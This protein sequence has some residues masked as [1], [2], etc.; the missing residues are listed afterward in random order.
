MSFTYFRPY[1]TVVDN[2]GCPISIYSRFLIALF[3]LGIGLTASVIIKE[4]PQ[5]EVASAPLNLDEASGP[6]NGSLESFPRDFLL[7]SP[8]PVGSYRVPI[9][10]SA[11]SSEPLRHRVGKQ[12]AEQPPRLMD[13]TYPGSPALSDSEERP[14]LPSNFHGISE[15]ELLQFGYIRHKTVNGDRLDKLAEKY[16]HDE[17]RWKEIYELNRSELS[18]KDVVPIGIVLI[19]PAE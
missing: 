15:E 4:F 16:L 11:P 8:D 5:N 1:L 14:A 17:N 6:V 3:V 13:K 9:R 2:N 7:N 19:I 12:P 10:S 18:N